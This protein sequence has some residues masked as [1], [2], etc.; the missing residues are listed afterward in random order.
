MYYMLFAHVPFLKYMSL[1]NDG[2]FQLSFWQ[3]GWAFFVT[4]DFKVYDKENP[5]ILNE[6]IDIHTN[7]IFCECCIRRKTMKA[8]MFIKV[9]RE[10]WCKYC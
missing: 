5:E 10:L 3:R 4:Q 6:S 8:L 9:K 1:L 2:F 7:Q